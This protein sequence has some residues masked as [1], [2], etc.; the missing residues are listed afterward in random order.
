MPRP[1]KHFQK[2]CQLHVAWP[3]IRAEHSG[4]ISLFPLL[5]IAP[6][7]NGVS[8]Q[9]WRCTSTLSCAS[10]GKAG[11]FLALD[12]NDGSPVGDLARLSYKAHQQLAKELGRDV[13]YRQVNTLS[14]KAASLK[15]EAPEGAKLL[16]QGPPDKH[17]V[18]EGHHPSSSACLP[19]REQLSGRGRCMHL[20]CGSPCDGACQCCICKTAAATRCTMSPCRAASE[21]A[22]DTGQSTASLGTCSSPL[23]VVQASR[24]TRRRRAACLHGLMAT[25]TASRWDLVLAQK[26]CP[27]SA[28]GMLCTH[29]ATCAVA[30][31]WRLYHQECVVWPTH[32]EPQ[33]FCQSPNSYARHYICLIYCHLGS[34]PSVVL[35]Q[36]ASA[37]GA[38]IGCAVRSTHSEPQH[39]FWCRTKCSALY[40]PAAMHLAIS[41]LQ[42]CCIDDPWGSSA[43]WHLQ[44]AA[45]PHAANAAFA[46]QHRLDLTRLTG[47]HTRLSPVP[48]AA[49][50]DGGPRHHSPGAPEEAE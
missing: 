12:W 37:G 32:S 24:A 10:A 3:H 49:A 21:R 17:F 16:P 31:C 14:V 41:P 34:V 11:G 43:Y 20:G 39:T 33:K 26:C 15:G 5:Q 46:W 4:A 29:R 47:T 30:L 42:M 7:Q 48:H 35:K 28:A 23:T 27:D 1:T 18:L 36:W 2:V 50:G 19:V 22:H 45:A 40:L 44:P 38:G 8:V 13:G 6:Q 9:P 25:S